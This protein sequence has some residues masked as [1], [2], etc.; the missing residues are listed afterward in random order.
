[1]TSVLTTDRRKGTEKTVLSKVEIGE[2]LIKYKVPEAG[3]N[4]E[5]HFLEL[6]EEKQFS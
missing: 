4:K 5:D 3:S 6:S 1:M 2:L